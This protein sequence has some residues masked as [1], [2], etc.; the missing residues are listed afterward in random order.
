MPGSMEKAS[1]VGWDAPPQL[2][3]L[4]SFRA[5]AAL[6]AERAEELEEEEEE[7]DEEEE[8]EEEEEEVG[9]ASGEL[10]PP[11]SLWAPVCGSQPGEAPLL[12]PLL[13]LAL[14]C[15][16]CCCCCCVPVSSRI[17]T[18]SS[19]SSTL[20]R[21]RFTPSLSWMPCTR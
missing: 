19:A 6:M 17:L 7:E 10:L 9:A 13:P 8:E 18:P 5:L 12:G 14:T 20:L 2:L 1:C 4:C 21:S 16:C 11:A 3:T 15:F